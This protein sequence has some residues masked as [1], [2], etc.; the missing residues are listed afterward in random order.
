MPPEPKP[1]GLAAELVDAETE[2]RPAP[3]QLASPLARFA[4]A[5]SLVL[6]AFNLRPVFSSLAAVLPEIRGATGAS[7]ATAS[8][9]TTVPVL[10]LGLFAGLAP[11]LAHR[12]G[13]ERVILSLVLLLTAG[14]AL[15]GVG[16][17]PALLAGSVLAGAAIAIVNVLLPGLVKRDFS[18]RVAT[19]TAF[20]T[21]AL[22]AGAAAAAGV[23]VPFER[24]TGA[25][26][27]GALAAWGV[28]AL[29]VALIWA[30]QAM[31]PKAPERPRAP[32]AG[33]SLLRE[34]LAWQVT[35]FMGLQSALA[36]C[37]F[38]WFA[39]LLRAR[40]LD[41]A[42]A[43]YVVSFS[44]LMQTAACLIAPGLA[45]RGRSQS[46]FNVAIVALAVVGFLGALFAPIGTVWVWAGLQGL[47]QGSLIAVALTV[48]VLRA[49]DA[50][51][52]ARLS[53]MAQ[54][55]GYSIAA[56]GPLATGYLF[57]STGE[58]GATAPLIVALGAGA[59]VSGWFAGRD[60][61]LPGR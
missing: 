5:V 49:P 22:C 11:R 43:G 33:G 14:T 45:T 59:A 50:A 3:A 26:W 41:A 16:T 54:G 29:A 52:A 51:T 27:Q 57:T 13:A 2:A 55:F 25:G 17:V 6:V 28:P 10:C 12:F 20:Y 42:T 30:P 37:I 56:F 19:V 36:Y 38:G 18:D 60:R 53:S 4:L 46:A 1:T 7:P 24:A 35:G 21:M 8:L 61:L 31:R 58:P 44:V 34:P 23:T 15:R 48:I 39:P 32:T 47:G 40:G 9:L